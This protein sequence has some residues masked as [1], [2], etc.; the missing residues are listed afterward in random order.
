MYNP[1]IK[2]TRV[3]L[4]LLYS[5]FSADGREMYNHLIKLKFPSFFYVPHSP[6]SV[7]RCVILLYI[8]NTVSLVVLY[9]TFSVAGNPHSQLSVGKC[10]ILL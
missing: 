3:P 5:Q 10:I 2:E 8:E 7:E 4:V 1:L 9:T 6:L